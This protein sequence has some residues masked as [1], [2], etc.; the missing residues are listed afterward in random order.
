MRWIRP[1][2]PASPAAL[3]ASAAAFACTGCDMLGALFQV[4]TLLGIAFAVALVAAVGFLVSR[5][6]RRR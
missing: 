4:P 5:G 1:Q 2:L 3:V 6:A